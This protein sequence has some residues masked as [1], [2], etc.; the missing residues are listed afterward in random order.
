M[1]RQP[2][3]RHGLVPARRCATTRAT[4]RP[5]SGCSARTRAPRRS[6]TARSTRSRPIAVEQLTKF[7]DADTA[8]LLLDKGLA[9]RSMHSHGR[10]LNGLLRARGADDVDALLRARGRGDLRR[11]SP[12]GT[13]A[14]GTSTTTSC[15]TRCRSRCQ[16]EPGDLRV[17]MLESQPA[18]IQRQHYRIHDAATGADRG[19][20]GQRARHGRARALAR[21]EL[22]SRW[23]SPGRREP[24]EPAPI[25]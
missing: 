24:A 4:G 12:A 13:S 18:H 2:A 11:S 7:Y 23:R 1:R 22:A 9:F 19:G 14:M 17:V 3:A 21:G 5:P 20:L 25:A 16:F 8:E 15:S 10:A 6:S